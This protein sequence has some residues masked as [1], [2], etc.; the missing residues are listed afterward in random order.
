VFILLLLL[1]SIS[2]AKDVNKLPIN[3]STTTLPLKKSLPALPPLS[4]PVECEDDDKDAVEDWD[5]STEPTELDKFKA[6]NPEQ[7]P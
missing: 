5:T 4:P 7:H 6:Q 1:G 2:F 3:T